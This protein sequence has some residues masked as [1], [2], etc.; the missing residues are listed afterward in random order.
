[1]KKLDSM[2]HEDQREFYSCPLCGIGMG[3]DIDNA[4]YGSPEHDCPEEAEYIRHYK[5]IHSDKL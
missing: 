3:N 1:M 4:V 2:K 5:R